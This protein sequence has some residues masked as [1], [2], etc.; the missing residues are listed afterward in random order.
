MVLIHAHSANKSTNIVQK[1]PCTSLNTNYRSNK[2]NL[3]SKSCD[4][5]RESPQLLR[6]LRY[7]AIVVN[8][9]SI[10]GV[11]THQVVIWPDAKQFSEVTEGNRSIG[12]KTKVTV[13]MSGGQVAAFTGNT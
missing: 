12:L 11:S 10:L 1:K 8:M 2:K 5:E 13:V 7:T 3:P 9:E 4:S 6:R